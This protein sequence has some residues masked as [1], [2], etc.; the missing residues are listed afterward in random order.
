[1]MESFGNIGS[2]GFFDYRFC[3][4]YNSTLYKHFRG[5]IVKIKSRNTTNEQNVLEDY[6]DDVKETE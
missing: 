6:D 3:T 5:S 4:Y 2:M 1:M